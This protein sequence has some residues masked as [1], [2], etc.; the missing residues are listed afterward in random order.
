MGGGGWLPVVSHPTCSLSHLSPL[1]LSALRH[2]A[3][4]A[5][6][7]QLPLL[8]GRLY[9]RASWCLY[10]RRKVL[11]RTLHLKH[12]AERYRQ[13]RSPRSTLGQCNLPIGI[14]VL[15]LWLLLMPESCTEN[16]WQKV[17][18]TCFSWAL[19]KPCSDHWWK[20]LETKFPFSFFFQRKSKRERDR[21]RKR[22]REASKFKANWME[23]APWPWKL[24]SIFIFWYLGDQRLRVSE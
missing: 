13:A 12:L 11:W 1:S 19:G 21:E 4:L 10:R 17:T 8:G 18:R 23:A 2:L 24:L 22:E 9:W 20:P 16:P 15:G 14:L 6:A 3:W 5:A 7:S